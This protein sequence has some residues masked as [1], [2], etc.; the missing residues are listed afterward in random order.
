MTVPGNDGALTV[1][2]L[3][4]GKLG[5][6]LASL[7][8]G[9][10]CDV[11]IAASGDPKFIALNVQLYAHG[12]TAT[13]ADDAIAGADLVIL[14]L[15]FHRVPDLPVEALSGRI[16]V[17]A[18]N[19]WPRADGELPAFASSASGT[20]GAIAAQLPGARL[21]KALGHVGYADLEAH[22]RDGRGIALG[23]AS[24]DREA[25]DAVAEFV[26][27]LGFEPVAIGDLAAGAALEPGGRA[28]GR[29]LDRDGLL[30]AVTG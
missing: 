14:A 7:A 16:V 22:A 2:V 5:T 23:I 28:F 25:A 4:A 26:R 9:A 1:A 3:G 11:R 27:R 8:V 18:T 6:V 30:R 13:T 19:Y 17:D 24:D 10:G 20:S 15:P 29:A 12:A 21:V